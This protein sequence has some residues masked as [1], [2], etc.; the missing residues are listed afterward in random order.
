[1][2]HQFGEP[3][4]PWGR[5]TVLSYWT[6]RRDEGFGAEAWRALRDLVPVLGLAIK[7]A[8][9]ADI[10]RNLGRSI[11]GAMLPSRFCRG[12]ISRGRDRTDQ[13]RAVVF[14]PARSTAISESIESPDE[15]IPFSTTYAQ[16]SIDAITTPA[17]EV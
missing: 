9:Q 15:I 16:A 1:M 14:R 4:A 3:A 11:S 8:A 6:T 13:G 7:S 12:R 17:G 2:L 5:W 10:A